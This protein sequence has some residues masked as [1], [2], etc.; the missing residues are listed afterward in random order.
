MHA[1]LSLTFVFISLALILAPVAQGDTLVGEGISGQTDSKHRAPL[2]TVGIKRNTGSVSLLVDASIADDEYTDLPIQFDFFINRDKVASQI[3]SK[4]L[5]GPVGYVVENT[6]IPVPFNYAVVATLLHPNRQFVTVIQG[7]VYSQE[8][9]QTYADCSLTIASDEA[10]AIYTASDVEAGQASDTTV[11]STFTAKNDSE[12]VETS[13]TATKE[14]DGTF[15]G[16]LTY[17]Q[18]KEAKTAT[19][20][21]TRTDTKLTLSSEDDT[22][23]LICE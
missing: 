7:A 2:V 13:F 6:K 23:S 4:E 20:S 16:S 22:V 8:L 17:T 9:A 1:R 19:V 5:P 10:E 14:E 3:R 21:G 12:S 11:T 15:S 18:E